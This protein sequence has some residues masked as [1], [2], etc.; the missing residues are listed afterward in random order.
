MHRDAPGH[1][2]NNF[3]H[4]DIEYYHTARP[5]PPQSAWAMPGDSLQEYLH[6]PRKTSCPTAHS[7]SG[8]TATI[9]QPPASCHFDSVTLARTVILTIIL[10]KNRPPVRRDDPRHRDKASQLRATLVLRHLR[11]RLKKTQLKALK[12][13]RT[14]HKGN[15]TN[16]PPS[17]LSRF[18]DK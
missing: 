1:C 6:V 13:G 17:A 14:G 9:E 10:R 15:G 8:P 3:R 12:A 4:S 18:C 2:D 7:S 16:S 11:Q 5:G